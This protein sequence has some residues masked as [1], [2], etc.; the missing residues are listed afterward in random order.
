MKY[1]WWKLNTLIR[2][3]LG[4]FDALPDVYY[5]FLVDSILAPVNFVVQCLKHKEC[6]MIEGALMKGGRGFPDAHKW[7]EVKGEDNIRKAMR[8]AKAIELPVEGVEETIVATHVCNSKPVHFLS[9]SCAE[10]KWIKKTR[11]HLG[12]KMILLWN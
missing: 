4:L 10:I 9:S 7:E 11:N 5:K 12:R 1:V 3:V 2:R 8:D 6:A